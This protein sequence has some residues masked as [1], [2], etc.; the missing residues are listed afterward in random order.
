M[1]NE[2]RR[3]ELRASLRVLQSDAA[4]T[5]PSI[6][7]PSIVTPRIVAPRR[8]YVVTPRPAADEPLPTAQRIL[9]S[10]WLAAALLAAVAVLSDAAAHAVDAMEPRAIASL[11]PSRSHFGFGQ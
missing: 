5:A 9:V 1:R 11:E 8:L 6:A 7:A 2:L 10:A 3:D 4:E